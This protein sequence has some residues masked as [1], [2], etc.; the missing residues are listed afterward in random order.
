MDAC[1]V[2]C[3]VTGVDNVGGVTGYA[4]DN[5]GGTRLIQN[6][7]VEGSVSCSGVE[8]GGIAGLAKATI[9]NNIVRNMTASSTGKG[10]PGSGNVAGLLGA[11]MQNLPAELSIANNVV[12]SGSVSGGL[13][14]GKE[15]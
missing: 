10:E 1:Y 9:Q 4:L 5:A 13:P 8:A 14:P 12:L 7:I 2:N 15:Q 6:C 3:H 11:W